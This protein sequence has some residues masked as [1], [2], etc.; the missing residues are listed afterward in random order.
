VLDGEVAGYGGVLGFRIDRLV[1]GRYVEGPLQQIL[2]A[3]Y[4]LNGIGDG[5]FRIECFKP[6]VLDG[7]PMPF[8]IEPREP[9]ATGSF[10]VVLR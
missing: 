9:G 2:R 5:A 7:K 1:E 3:P 10:E 4:V 8:E 6:P